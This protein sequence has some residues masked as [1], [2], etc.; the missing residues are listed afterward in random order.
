MN[1]AKTLRVRVMQ[2]QTI[3]FGPGKADLL[4]A[5]AQTGSISGAAREMD[6][7][8]RRAWLLVEE[9][10]RCF[11]SP[12]VATAT[13]G[14]RGG[15]AAVTELGQEVLARYRRMQKKAA[16]SIAGELRQLQALMRPA[17]EQGA[18]DQRQGQG[19]DHA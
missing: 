3:A 4:Q 8:Y 14:A 15:G 1:D 16:A 9:M 2:G 19:S 13:G 12:L 18:E 7:S 5:I 10:N 6:M 17:D 11:A